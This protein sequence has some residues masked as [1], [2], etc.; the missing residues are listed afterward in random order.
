MTRY[1]TVVPIR[2]NVKVDLNLDVIYCVV[3]MIVDMIVLV[4]DLPLCVRGVIGPCPRLNLL[5]PT[6]FSGKAD[7]I[8]E[9]VVEASQVWQRGK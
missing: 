1:A 2:E 3:V 5:Q 7:P 4:I 8:V 6:L 9:S